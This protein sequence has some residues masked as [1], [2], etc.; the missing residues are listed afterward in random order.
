MWEIFCPQHGLPAI[1]LWLML[2]ADPSIF[3]LTIQMYYGKLRALV[4]ED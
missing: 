2:G 4:Q 1:I 3:V